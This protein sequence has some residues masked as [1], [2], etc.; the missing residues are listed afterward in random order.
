MILAGDITGVGKDGLNIDNTHS[1]VKRIGFAQIPLVCVMARYV[2]EAVRYADILSDEG[3]SNHVLYPMAVLLTRGT[4]IQ[5][6]TF[7]FK[8]LMTLLL[9]KAILNHFIEKTSRTVIMYGPSV[10]EESKGKNEL[11]RR[12]A[13]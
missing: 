2:A 10:K 1:A 13:V 7:L 8:S 6:A 4:W 5:I 12:Q 9:L 3:D 11:Q